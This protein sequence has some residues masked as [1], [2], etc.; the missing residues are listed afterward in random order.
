MLKSAVTSSFVLAAFTFEY[1]GYELHR[2]YSYFVLTVTSSWLAKALSG[3]DAIQVSQATPSTL[4]ANFRLYKQLAH[5]EVADKM[6]G[7]L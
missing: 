5:A 4:L 2:H 1:D 7:L 3:T 6:A